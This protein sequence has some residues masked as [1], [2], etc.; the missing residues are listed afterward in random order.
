MIELLSCGSF[1]LPK[2]SGRE[3]QDAL[4]LPQQCG[5]GFIF[6]IADG[7]GSYAGAK[8]AA[9]IAVEYVAAHKLNASSDPDAVFSGIKEKIAELSLVETEARK[10]ATTLSYCAI[11]GEV[12]NIFHVGDTRVY[13]RIN[14]KLRLLTKDH[15]QHQELLDEG[16]YTKKELEGLPGKNMLTSA[17]SKVL[18]IQFQ[19]I[20]LP[21]KG[22][23]DSD[24]IVTIFIMSDGA[25]HFWERRPHFSLNT[26]KNATSF[27]TNLFKRIQRIGPIDDH[28]LIAA[29]FK[30][31]QSNK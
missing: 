9:K 17:L 28:S 24:G 13:V 19:H 4:L 30:V 8:E 14:N 20:T 10:A 15:T 3:N 12:L 5:D 6:A 25:H 21:L 16:L 11:S 2:E 31:S 18:P 29:S 1:S 27:S 26:L 22:L 7:V 23:M